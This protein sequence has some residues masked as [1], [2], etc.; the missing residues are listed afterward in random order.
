MK[1]AFSIC[2]LTCLPWSFHTFLC[3]THCCNPPFPPPL[4]SL[5]FSPSL[6]ATP[7]PLYKPPPPSISVGLSLSPASIP[8]NAHSQTRKHGADSFISY[9]KHVQRNTCAHFTINMHSALGQF[10]RDRRQQIHQ[11]LMAQSIQE[12]KNDK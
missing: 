6:Y 8:R 10:P 4:R 12:I 5:L 2:S 9:T 7:L 3:L 1:L 11:S